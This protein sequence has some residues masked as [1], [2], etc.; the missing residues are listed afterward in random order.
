MTETCV[1]KLTN[2]YDMYNLNL[3]TWPDG[4]TDGQRDGRMDRRMDGYLFGWMDR[5]ND[6]WM[7]L[8]KFHL[9]ILMSLMIFKSLKCD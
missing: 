9:V 5:L 8:S 4:W 7:E 1:L 2:L 3:K 6:G